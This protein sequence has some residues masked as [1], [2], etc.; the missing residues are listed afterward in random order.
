MSFLPSGG[1]IVVCGT[2]LAWWVAGFMVLTR[3]FRVEGPL[4]GI[5]GLICMLYTYIWGWSKVKDPNLHLKTWMWIWTAAIGLGI[6]VN[7]V[8]ASS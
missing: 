3:L 1:E 7:A 6:I 2:V 8:A 4:K 5:L